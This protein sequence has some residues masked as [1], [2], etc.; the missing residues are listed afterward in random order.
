MYTTG[1]GPLVCGPGYEYYLIEERVR[2][3]AAQVDDLTGR[4][5]QV[6]AIDWQSAA[7]QA[8]RQSLL[9]HRRAMAELHDD[10]FQVAAS[11][12]RLA[13]NAAALAAI[14]RSRVGG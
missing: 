10:I 1:A 7:G 4:I 14:E 13:D 11:L 3:C 5:Q 9:E 6:H 8:F 12:R 2:S